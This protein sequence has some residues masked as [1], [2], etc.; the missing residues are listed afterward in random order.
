MRC[1]NWERGGGGE[2]GNTGPFYR[3]PV[4]LRHSEGLPSQHIETVLDLVARAST[5][6]AIAVP[7]LRGAAPDARSNLDSPSIRAIVRA[8]RAV[9][10]SACLFPAIVLGLTTTGCET[11]WPNTCDR[12]DQNNPPIRYTG[13]TTENGIY[14][15]SPWTSSLLWFPGGMQYALVH[16]LGTTPREWQAYLSFSEAGS[17]DGGT[18]ALASGNAVSLKSENDTTLTVANDGCADFW[19]VVVASA[20][21]LPTP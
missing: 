3:G 5:S 19:L 1:E 17:G 16:N 6:S 21:N 18:L 9:L 14:M 10:R 12:S 11:F 13:G 15:S 2:A 8:V 7:L 4:R 20:G